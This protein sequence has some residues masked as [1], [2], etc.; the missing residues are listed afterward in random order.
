MKPLQHKRRINYNGR[1][2][3]LPSKEDEIY[4]QKVKKMFR[5]AGVSADCLKKH[6]GLDI[7]LPAETKQVE[8]KT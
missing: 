3:V 7:G 1:S 2:G 5:E 8:K 6:F 4:A